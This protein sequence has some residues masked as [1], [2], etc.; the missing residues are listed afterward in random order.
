MQALKASDKRKSRSNENPEVSLLIEA[1]VAALQELE[2]SFPREYPVRL[3]H[4]LGRGPEPMHDVLYPTDEA[5]EAVRLPDA[6]EWTEFAQSMA[7][8]TSKQDEL[9]S[10]EPDLFPQEPRPLSPSMFKVTWPPVVSDDSM[11]VDNPSVSK[12]SSP[13]STLLDG[14]SDLSASFSHIEEVRVDEERLALED[15]LD[16]FDA[17]LKEEEDKWPRELVALEK[18]KQQYPKWKEEADARVRQLRRIVEELEER[19]KRRR[20]SNFTLR[21]EAY[22][23]R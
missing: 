5:K 10:E 14:I 7:S 11:E 20:G 3:R 21:V 12:D 19:N 16:E 6:E 2:A 17:K 15:L 4:I 22:K 8:I 18:L 23:V 1:K 13:F 9:V